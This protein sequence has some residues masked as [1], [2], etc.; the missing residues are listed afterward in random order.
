MNLFAWRVVYGPFITKN[1]DEKETSLQPS[2]HES[3]IQNSTKK[4]SQPPLDSPVSAYLD[5]LQ[6]SLCATTEQS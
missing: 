4:H 6:D 5:A 1:I 3:Q 2:L